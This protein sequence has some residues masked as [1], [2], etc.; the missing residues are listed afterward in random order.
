MGSYINTRRSIAKSAQVEDELVNLFQYKFE[1]LA[2]T[3]AYIRELWG[4]TS[5]Y[6]NSAIKMVVEIEDQSTNVS[7]KSLRT[8][9][10]VGVISGILGYLARDEIPKLSTF[11][12]A[13]FVLL[14]AATWT[15]NKI[16]MTLYK[17]RKYKIKFTERAKN[18]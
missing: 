17:R 11:G 4:M 3:H 12:I 14:V 2:N 1:T 7:I 8:I 9:T 6:L 13:Y 18:I 16:I 5:N 10:M 15:L